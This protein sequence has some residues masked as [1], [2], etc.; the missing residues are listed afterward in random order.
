MKE[1]FSSTVRLVDV[2]AGYAWPW[3][4]DTEVISS[5]SSALG[6]VEEL[7]SGERWSAELVRQVGRFKL[8]APLTVVA[9][10]GGDMV[11]DVHARGEDTKVG[12]RL[13]AH[14]RLSLSAVPG[15]SELRVVGDYEVTGKLASLGAGAV[16]KHANQMVQEFA[17]RLPEAIRGAIKSG[18]H[19]VG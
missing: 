3:L 2:D 13:V 16:R 7:V 6:R 18:G 1:T 11:L 10:Q 12:S 4:R 17:E 15:G 14:V 8:S 19:D 5:C 9:Q